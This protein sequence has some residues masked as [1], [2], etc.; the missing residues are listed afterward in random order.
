MEDTRWLRLETLFD[1]SKYSAEIFDVSR[2]SL[3]TGNFSFSIV[4]SRSSWFTIRM[5]YARLVI[6]VSG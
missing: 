2:F 3:D 5:V 4:P 1:M 6:G